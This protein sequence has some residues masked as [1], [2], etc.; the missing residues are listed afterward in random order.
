M[1]NQDLFDQLGFSVIDRFA[2]RIRAIDSERTFSKSNSELTATSST[3]A[4]LPVHLNKFASLFTLDPNKSITGYEH[5]MVVNELM[6][7]VVQPLR[8][9]PLAF[10]PKIKDE[11]DRLVSDGVLQQVNATDWV[12]NLVIARKANSAIRICIDLTSVNKAIIIDS[13][14]LPTIEELSQFVRNPTVFTKIDF[15]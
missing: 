5:K 2:T 6:F 13:Y 3:I 14:P 8:R 1:L 9:V 11:L 12:S 10:L 7:S 4:T 15:I